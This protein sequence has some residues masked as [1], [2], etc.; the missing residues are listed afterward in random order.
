MRSVEDRD[1]RTQHIRTKGECLN[2]TYIFSY[3]LVNVFLF[4]LVV[5]SRR[6]M[7]LR[8]SVSICLR[9]VPH[10]KLGPHGGFG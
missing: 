10:Q 2:S 6:S 1:K 8:R 4:Y 5:T 3:V 7:P 9:V